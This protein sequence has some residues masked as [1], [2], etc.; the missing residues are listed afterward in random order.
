MVVH[1][2]HTSATP[3]YRDLTASYPYP[4]RGGGKRL[5]LPAGPIQTGVDLRLVT[6]QV[7]TFFK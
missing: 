1:N 2:D 6:M 3:L 7:G 5:V 4:L